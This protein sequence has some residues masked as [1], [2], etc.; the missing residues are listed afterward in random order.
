MICPICRHGELRP[1]S[2]TVALESNGSTVVF[3][4]V[5]ADVCNNCAEQY[6]DE[7]T[8]T[9]LLAETDRAAKAGV[10]VEVRSYAA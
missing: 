5:P 3:K 4:N 6:V 1:G 8:T 2:A 10:E 7:A 9:R